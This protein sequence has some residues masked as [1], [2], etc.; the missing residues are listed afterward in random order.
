MQ[1]LNKM[2]VYICCVH[3]SVSIIII[4]FVVT[5]RDK[6]CS[7]TGDSYVRVCAKKSLAA[8]KSSQTLFALLSCSNQHYRCYKSSVNPCHFNKSLLKEYSNGKDFDGAELV[9]YE[10][11]TFHLLRR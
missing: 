2:N 8:F 4:C 10:S 6:Y 5:V 11:L 1:C 3:S 9:S 7:A